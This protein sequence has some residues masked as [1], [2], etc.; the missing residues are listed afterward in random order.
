MSRRAVFLDRDGVLLRDVGPTRILD[1]N[2]I[3]PGAYEAV[4]RLTSA[5]FLNVIVTNQTAIAR[6]LLTEEAVD[7]IHRR[8]V[9]LFSKSGGSIDAVYFCPHHP[10]ATLPQYRK[11]C[12]CRKPA[13]GMLIQAAGDLDIDL[14]GSF[15]IGD[16]LSDIAAGSRAGVRTVLLKSGRHE[17]DP[18]RS[19]RWPEVKAEPD[20]ECDT[21]PDA[22]DIILG[23]LS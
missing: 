22:V 23:A 19:S 6:G 12:D 11:D 5:G 18:I 16:R 13:A 7:Q 17:D 15:L 20:F 14:S 21:L 9:E 4:A 3:M 8:L 10:E 1:P 2:L